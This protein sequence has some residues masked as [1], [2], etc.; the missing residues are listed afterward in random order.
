MEHVKNIF[1]TK[2][3][4]FFNYLQET[5]EVINLAWKEERGKKASITCGRQIWN[6]FTNKSHLN[7][8]IMSL[9]NETLYYVSPRI[10]KLLKY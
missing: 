4:H 5:T 3:F 2:G 7:K 1:Q 9:N 8:F 10:S 6:L